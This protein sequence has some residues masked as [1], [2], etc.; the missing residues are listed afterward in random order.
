MNHVSRETRG[1]EP[2]QPF[3]SFLRSR[4]TLRSWITGA[5]ENLRGLKTVHLGLVPFLLSFLKMDEA[6]VL[7]LFPEDRGEDLNLVS[8]Y[9]M[10]LGVAG[11]GILTDAGF[12]VDQDTPSLVSSGVHPVEPVIN[13]FCRGNLSLLLALDTAWDSTRVARPRGGPGRVALTQGNSFSLGRL[14]SS[15]M[16]WGYERVDRVQVPGSFAI[17]GGIVDIFP[18]ELDTP[19]RLEFLGNTVDSGRLF[20]PVTQRTLRPLPHAGIVLHAPL[21]LASSGGRPLDRVRP[22]GVRTFVFIPAGPSLTYHI[23]PHRR[24]A[25]G[26]PDLN[27]VH[28]GPFHGN[29]QLWVDLNEQLSK[30]QINNRFIFAHPDYESRFRTVPG[31]EAFVPIPFPLPASF[32]SPPL[33][34]FCASLEQV[35]DLPSSRPAAALAEVPATSIERLEEFPWGGPVVHE[36]FGV[37]LYRGLT[38]VKA[39]DHVTECVSIEYTGGDRVYVPLDGLARVHT[40]VGSSTKPPELSSLGTSRWER[41]K[42]KTRKS[43]DEVVDR[44]IHLYARRHRAEGTA[45]SPDSDLHAA[46]KNSFPYE[47][48]PDQVAAYE[49]IRKAMERAT[50]MDWLLCGDVG[51]GKTEIALRAA[52]K[53]AYDHR[54]VAVLAPTTILANQL[55]VTLR[56][57]LEPLSV[58]VALLSRFTPRSRERPILKNLT[59]GNLDVIV[60]THRLL[61]RDVDIPNLGLVIVDEEHR[62][63][64]RHKERL[65]EMRTSVDVLSMS[66]TPIPRTLTFSLLGIRD[67]STIRTPPRER[68]SV[69]TRLSPRSDR[70]IRR[71]IRYEL[72]RGGQ[73]FYIHNDVQT[74][75]AVASRLEA[76][77]PGTRIGIAH[78]Q[79]P[80]RTL[81]SV[82][83]R[84][85]QKEIDIL[86]CT[87]IIEAGIDLPNVNTI[88]I[89][90]AHRFGLA[91]IY[92]MRGRVGRSNRQAFCYLFLPPGKEIT[93]AAHDR[94]KTLEFFSSLGSGYAIALRDLELRGAGN[95]FGTEQS[96]HI[97]SVG[98][99]LYCRMVE[100]AANARLPKGSTP[101][102]HR[103][104]Q[105]SFDGP[106]LIP[107]SYVPDISDRLYFYR[108]LGHARD[109]KAVQGVRSELRDRFGPLPPECL[110][111]LFVA[112]IQAEGTGS[113]IRRMAVSTRGIHAVFDAS[114][115]ASDA[116]A[117]AYRIRHRLQA[118]GLT[119]E[120]SETSPNGLEVTVS[121]RSV[122]RAFEATQYLFESI[123]PSSNFGSQETESVA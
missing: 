106:A 38:Q 45:F 121:T 41:L 20:D 33:S 34:L 12:S 10:A 17:R 107:P 75:D 59:Q 7:C 123:R 122:P 67:I 101:L 29:R 100:E 82:M 98:F 83:L 28:H 16:D 97:A 40:Y 22:A 21:R 111:L 18:L 14:S 76:L 74:L 80:G 25:K 4:P 57:R 30:K 103:P 73:V 23:A 115:P 116:R 8:Q 19:V 52:F 13:R 117:L 3:L 49:D 35:E 32:S 66:A 72:A 64:A 71:G 94:L 26:S 9:L 102:P 53:A 96:G 2:L 77:I 99:H 46:L 84:F 109:G 37:G 39:G 88:F 81:E 78:G 104:I 62:F 118:L 11:A 1:R 113:G 68:L 92:Q 86:V 55:F 90:N 6:P 93:T 27:C 112:A 114:L 24:P 42:E 47:E 95:L 110:N 56:A 85:L 48:T 54:Q 63:G 43:A 60:G 58:S 61:S 105:V 44:F 50:P 120:V 91:Q 5:G 31:I 15:L 108:L 69:I 89:D 36:D 70:I 119:A 87:T 51:F 65:K 79:L